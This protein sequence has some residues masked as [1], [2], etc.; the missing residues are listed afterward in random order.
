MSRLPIQDIIQRY[1][2]LSQ[3]LSIVTDTKEMIELSKEQSKLEKKYDLATK[4]QKGE[5]IISDNEALIIEI[6]NTDSDMK[7]MMF[8]E[9]TETKEKISELEGQLITLLVLSDPRDDNDI[10]LEI[11]AGAGGDESA[12]FA[13]ELLK[14]Y[15]IMAEKIG[16]K[17]K[18]VDASL[19]EIGG[20]KEVY[21]EIRGSGA[22]SWYK[23]ESGVHRVQ[24]VP[25][26]EKQG[27]IHT[28][29][30]SVAIMPLIEDSGVFK[31]D[32][33][34]VE[35]IVSTSSGKGGQSVNTTYSAVKLK[36]LPTGME[37]QSQD[38][39]SQV[40]N[41]VKAM[42]VL[43]SR[44]ADYYEQKRLA[45]EGAAR[46]EQVG[47]ADRSEKIRTYNF[48]QDRLTDHRYNNNWNQLPTIMTGGIAN[49][50][51][52]IKKIEA[53][54]TLENLQG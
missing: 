49:V 15:S 5:N 11:R 48:P 26:T 2:E 28:S 6:A 27:R 41:K 19:N 1:D 37:A 36:H 13:A 46:R 51:E 9:I 24:R 33:K 39:R 8:E 18:V 17:L 38:E 16:L 10:L 22:F 32:P 4:I 14:T 21:A 52:D 34:D 25:L 3:K 47:K 53:E 42:S 43:T 20:Y 40:Q 45:E 30:I 29:T 50:I 12:L 7:E 54:Q 23:Y 44:V 31:L 35:L